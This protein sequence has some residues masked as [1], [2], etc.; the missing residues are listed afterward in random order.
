MST[1]LSP[2]KLRELEEE[3]E[4]ELA[5]EWDDD[6]SP[7]NGA[8]LLRK[9][10]EVRKRILYVF[11]TLFVTASIAGVYSQVIFDFLIQPLCAAGTA[12]PV[13]PGV[14]P[15]LVGRCMLYPTSPLEPMLVLFKLSLLIGL[16]ATA[17]VLFYQV[18]AMI[19]EY[20][21]SKTKAWMIGFVGGAT[22]FFV[23][24]AAFGFFVVFPPAFAFMLSV[25]G[26]NIVTLATPSSYFS[27][28]SMLLLGFGA[29]FELPLLMFLLSR[30]G[31]TDYKFYLKYWRHSIFALFVFSAAITPTTDPVTMALMGGPLAVLYFVGLLMAYVAGRKGPTL[32][33][34][35]LR[36]LDEFKD[37]FEDDD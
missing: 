33:E 3:I 26:P 12:A 6:G 29:T 34:A 4:D 25:G 2:E 10:G 7:S 17:P 19:A 15:A 21:S 37:D 23:G 18:W 31:V 5:D 20:V 36:E 9:F 16:F 24:G 22:L 11:G 28:L 27:I 14:A 30:L 13:V 8:K 35:R 32:L 1:K